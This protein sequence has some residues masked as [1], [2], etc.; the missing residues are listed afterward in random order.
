[1]LTS[2]EERVRKIERWIRE[3]PPV[4]CSVIKLQG[5]SI[6][7][8]PKSHYFYSPSRAWDY[9][10]IHP[11]ELEKVKSS[12]FTPFDEP[13]DIFSFIQEMIPQVGPSHY[14]PKM[15]AL[16]E[17]LWKHDGYDVLYRDRD[18]VFLVL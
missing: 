7:M 8:P 5:F 9:P 16:L 11:D 6:P 3:L 17:K 15:V 10:D 1:M 4:S 13:E 12:I 2:H 14:A 18:S